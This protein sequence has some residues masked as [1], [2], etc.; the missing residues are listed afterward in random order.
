[1][2]LLAERAGRG[3]G[4]DVVFVDWQMPGL[5]GWDTARLIG[6][7]GL[8][9]RAP[10]VVMVTAHGREM[11]AQRSPA[12]QRLIDGFL[13]KPV[14]ASMLLDAVVDAH[15]SRQPPRPHPSQRTPAPA[16]QRLAGLRLLVVEDNP[17]N[18]Q[19]AREL[20]E[21]EG[22]LVQIA[23]DGQ[24]AVQ[25]VEAA[26][27]A[28]DAVL[29]D[30]QM[31]V[32]DGFTATRRIRRDLGLQSLPIVAMTANALPSDRDACLSAGMN[33]HVGKPFELDHLVAVLLR[34]TGHGTTP[35]ATP[36]APSAPS[37]PSVPSAP[38]TLL[39]TAL[40]DRA[41]AAG[42]DLAAALGRLGGKL[43]VYARLL[44]DFS[45]DLATLPAQLHAL[46]TAADTA[47][48]ARAL[49]T[50]KG[51]AA[52]LG[53]KALAGVAADGERLLAPAATASER[54][55]NDAPVAPDLAAVCATVSQA[56]QRMRPALQALLQDLQGA[57]TEAASEHDGG[58]HAIGKAAAAAAALRELV[59]L[60]ENSDMRATDLMARLQPPPGGP[61]GPAW[62]AIGEAVAAL[63][64]ERALRLC[65]PL[66]NE[67]TA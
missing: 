67:S 21:D 11:L 61:A 65:Q 56:S 31:P 62:H 41:A 64:F 23:A 24:L 63:D 34:V 25:A 29:M 42:I 8:G 44:R 16:A 43:P 5:D 19:V 66:L 38:A 12:E 55:P 39:P 36:S 46:A 47:G 2:A 32:M 50:L 59:A 35:A 49:H 28:F 18:Q 40:T 52:T 4:Y 15:R 9:G 3:E 14:T 51:L 10:V 54:T 45:D 57:A 53:A 7:R 1:L 22:A 13:V 48:L 60:L 33:D 30:L 26:V 58:D 17:N 6:E 27:P 20:L 37:A